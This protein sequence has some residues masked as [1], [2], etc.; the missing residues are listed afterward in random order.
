MIWHLIVALV[1]FGAFRLLGGEA[2]FKQAF[3]AT[4]YRM[5][6]AG[7]LRHHPDHRSHGAGTIDPTTMATVVKSNPAFLVDMKEQPVL[8]AL[9]SAIDVFTIWTIVLLSFG[10]SASSRFSLAKSASIV[11]TLL[12]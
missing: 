2:T 11:V 5:D 7:T 3:S 6:A 12:L 10:F 4:L 1:L 8:F 9:L